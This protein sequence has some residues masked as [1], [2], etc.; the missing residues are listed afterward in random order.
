[1]SY[2]LRH[3]TVLQRSTQEKKRQDT[4]DGKTLPTKGVQSYFV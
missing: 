1:M 3:I 2:L 4:P